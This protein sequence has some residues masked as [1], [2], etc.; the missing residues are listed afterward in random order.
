MN[1]KEAVGREQET[2]SGQPAADIPVNRHQEGADKQEN[3]S[4]G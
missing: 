2:R 3:I 4:P 1:A